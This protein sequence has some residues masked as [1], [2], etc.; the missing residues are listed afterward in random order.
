[1]VKTKLKRKFGEI[2]SFLQ[3]IE[4]L[5]EEK[6]WKWGLSWTSKGLDHKSQRATIFFSLFL[7]SL[8]QSLPYFLSLFHQLTPILHF[9]STSVYMRRSTSTVGSQKPRLMSPQLPVRI[10]YVACSVETQGSLCHRFNCCSPFS[11]HV[12]GTTKLP[13]WWQA[14]SAHMATS[15]SPE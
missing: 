11:Q 3:F 2:R 14:R 6:S 15:G 7:S 5:F 8:P 1:M 4:D 9:Q 12:G 13:R 10:S